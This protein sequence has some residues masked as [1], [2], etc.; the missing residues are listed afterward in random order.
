MNAMVTVYRKE[1]REMFRDKRVRSAAFFGP[2]VLIVMLM[3][4]LGG[5]VSKIGK[6]ENQKVHV[7]RTTNPIAEGLKK[8]KLNVI[9]I[10]SV[11]EGEKLVR[12]GKARVV[13]EFPSATVGSSQSVVNAYFDPKQ[14]LAQITLGV[15]GGAIDQANKKVLQTVLETKGIPTW[16][17]ESV[18]LQRKEVQVG[19]GKG[20]GD[21]IVGMLPYLIVI[22]AFY[23]GFGIVSD[24]VAG[25]KEKNTLETLLITPVRRTQIVLGK[26]LALATVSLLS[27]LSSVFGILFVGLARLPGTTELFKGGSG[28]TPVSFLIILAVLLPAVALFASILLAISSNAKNPREA[29]TQLTLVSFVV[30]MPAIFSQFIGLTDAASAMWVNFVPV[31]NTA[32]N[33]RLALLGKPEPMA[34]LITVVLSTVLAAIALRVAVWL[35]NREQVLTRV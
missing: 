23:G 1:L 13:L 30:I 14:Q 32:N 5:V 27:S 11:A 10:D 3:T 35:F 33:I 17:A 31:L 6:P 25:E 16:T 8:A 2:F 7:V 18:K 20:A 12:E 4:L 19:E 15:I 34:I 29:Q 9:E 22:W 28:V 26:F 21:F 24:L